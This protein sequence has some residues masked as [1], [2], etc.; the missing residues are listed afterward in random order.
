MIYIKGVIGFMIVRHKNLR[1]FMRSKFIENF[2]T[3]CVFCNTGVLAMD[4]LFEDD[5]SN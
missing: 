5:E 1:D 3:L 4:G 2:L